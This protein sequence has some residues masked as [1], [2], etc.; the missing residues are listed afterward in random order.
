MQLSLIV[1]KTSAKFNQSSASEPASNL[2]AVAP[3]TLNNARNTGNG[4]NAGGTF[5]I[6]A[7]YLAY[8]INKAWTMGMAFTTPFGLKTEYNRDWSG[9]SHAIK[10]DLKTY[11][12]SP[13]LSVKLQEWLSLGFGLN[14]QYS[15]ADLS[16]NIPV[17][18]IQGGALVNVVDA[19][20]SIKGNS[21]GFGGNFGVIVAP[22]KNL[23]FGLAWRTALKHKVKGDIT[24]DHRSFYNEGRMAA[25]GIATN[26]A[27]AEA[28]MKLPDIFTLSMNWAVNKTWDLLGTIE[29]TKWSTIP[30]LRVKFPGTV[31]AK[32][33]VEIFKY[34]NTF[35]YSLGSVFHLNKHFDFKL[36][37][38]YDQTPT[39][40]EHRSPR[41]P[42]ANRQWFSVGFGWKPSDNVNLDLSYSY[43]KINTPK[44]DLKGSTNPNSVEYT[45]GNLSGTYSANSHLVGLNMIYKF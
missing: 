26:G 18:T 5:L 11:D 14:I 3:P 2:L 32:D 7:I 24:Y 21:W 44:L 12:F 27:R 39:V 6:P 41:I 33:S 40:N 1:L 10:S 19:D 30:E 28:D 38:A 45:K 34:K 13:S 35:F 37:W 17:K 29:Y 8:K 20:A 23:K 42:D 31:G 36:G 4:G 25:A 16:R 43:I 9:R 22:L 15:E